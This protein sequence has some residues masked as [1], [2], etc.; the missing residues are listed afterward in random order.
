[1]K[2]SAGGW[3]PPPPPP[4]PRISVLELTKPEVDE[5]SMSHRPYVFGS[6]VTVVPLANWRR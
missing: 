5:A 6:K 4:R 2:E 3:R 1:M